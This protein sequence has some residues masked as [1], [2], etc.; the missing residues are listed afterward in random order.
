MAN[1]NVPTFLAH[2]GS[3]ATVTAVAKIKASVA[4]STVT[5]SNVV[6]VNVV[7]V[8]KVTANDVATSMV[9]VNF[10]APE[11]SYT[12]NQ[13][14]SMMLQTIQALYSTFFHRHS[15]LSKLLCMF[16]FSGQG[17]SVILTNTA[18]S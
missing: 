15:F 12:A 17:R 18:L 6:A 13:L 8:N 5:A 16:S 9:A 3:S 10:V 11:N 4:I 14:R 1:G 7:T 2:I